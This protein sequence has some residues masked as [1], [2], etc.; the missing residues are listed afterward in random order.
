MREEKE[1]SDCFL[2]FGL[3][4]VTISVLAALFQ[5]LTFEEVIEEVIAHPEKGT[6]D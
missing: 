4:I 2:F 3:L 5:V 6:S 1:L